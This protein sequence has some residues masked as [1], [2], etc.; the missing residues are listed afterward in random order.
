MRADFRRLRLAVVPLAGYRRRI[1]RRS[2]LR[3]PLSAAAIVAAL[4]LPAAAGAETFTDPTGD[5]IRLNSDG[6]TITAPDMT[7]AS[8][9]FLAD[10][11]IELAMS[12]GPGNCK[13]TG[14][15]AEYAPRAIFALYTETDS[16]APGLPQFRIQ[17]DSTEQ[18]WVI[19]DNTTTR[20][21]I[22]Q[23][24][25]IDAGGILTVHF[26]PQYIG[27]PQKLLWMGSQ[28]CI[29]GLP[30]EDAD[31]VPDVGF[32]S[33][34]LPFPPPPDLGY[35]PP[36]QAT[37]DP[38]PDALTPTTATTTTTAT[39]KR[40]TTAGKATVKLLAYGLPGSGRLLTLKGL[41]SGSVLA[42]LGKTTPLA[43]GDAYTKSGTASLRLKPTRAGR[44]ALH[45]TGTLKT[46]L[47]LVFTP[48]GGG[49]QTT[50]RIDVKL[51]RRR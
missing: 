40:L 31:V 4:A 34:A 2:S 3:V 38:I 13:S 7:Y 27:K 10:G 9:Q 47:R 23:I 35:D 49:K 1:V 26:D 46:R 33:L 8:Q 32:Y 28:R 12:F 44:I 41:P 16:A 21:N 22:A 6:Q 45:G 25:G 50:I 42:V 19:R 17:F 20:P 14:D 11:R 24:E 43:R 36:T 15:P 29:G 5:N 30:Y 51:K 18:S 39:A 37:G 48:T